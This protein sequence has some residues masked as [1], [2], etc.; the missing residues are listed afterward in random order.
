MRSE[1]LSEEFL[2]HFEVI[3][4]SRTSLLSHRNVTCRAP[5]SENF[6][7]NKIIGLNAILSTFQLESLLYKASVFYYRHASSEPL[8]DSQSSDV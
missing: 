1:M 7:I 4:T 3:L 2:L 5:S 6:R 8:M